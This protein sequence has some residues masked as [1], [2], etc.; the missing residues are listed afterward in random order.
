MP[1]DSIETYSPLPEVNLAQVYDNNTSI[2]RVY[3]KRTWDDIH[4]YDPNYS[5]QII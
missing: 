2:A 4:S 5:S 3:G 1:R